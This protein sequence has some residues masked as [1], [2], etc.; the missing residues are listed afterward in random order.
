MRRYTNTQDIA[1][2]PTEYD[3]ILFK[4]RL[5]ARWAVFFDLMRIKWEYE[6]QC[7]EQDDGECVIQYLPDFYLTELECWVEVKGTQNNLN[8]DWDRK[9][10]SI[11]D[12]FPSPIYETFD[13]SW[14]GF[15][16]L[17]SIPISDQTPYSFPCFTFIQ[18]D[19]GLWQTKCSFHPGWKEFLPDLFMIRTTFPHKFLCDNEYPELEHQWLEYRNPSNEEGFFCGVI[20]SALDS[21]RKWN[22]DK[23]NN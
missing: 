11:L 19:K 20:N 21:A 6:P 10:R 13:Y 18:H 12:W 3:G 7:F 17:G 4:S 14:R 15:I 5:E 16:I 9:M 1:A 2:I 8:A 22:F 23:E